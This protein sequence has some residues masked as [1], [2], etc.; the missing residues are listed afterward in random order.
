MSRLHI[1]VK[2]RLSQTEAKQRVTER[3]YHLQTK[4]AADISEVRIN[5][6]GNICHVE[7]T[8]MGLH[9]KP[10]IHVREHDVMVS[11]NVPFPTSLAQ[12]KIE[13][14]L[15]QNL[16]ESLASTPPAVVSNTTHTSERPKEGSTTSK[17]TP[18]TPSVSKQADRPRHL[19]PGTAT[20]AVPAAVTEQT[21]IVFTIVTP[22][23][24]IGYLDLEM[25]IQICAGGRNVQA[26][27]TST[28]THET[29][30]YRIGPL[31]NP[32]AWFAKGDEVLLRRLGSIQATVLAL[33]V[34][35]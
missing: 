17:V 32:K 11:G 19:L 26:T 34:R 14:L 25:S 20:I 16:E 24:V 28:S 33:C 4:H 9:L 2:H 27:R 6:Q 35:L 7:L 31:T 18:P 29:T 8:L 21:P 10:Q 15:R 3:M 30:I 22:I 13:Q 5:W 23:G 12:G 1:S